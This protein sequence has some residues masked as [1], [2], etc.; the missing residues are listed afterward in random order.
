MYI[1][2]LLV[3]LNTFISVWFGLWVIPATFKVNNTGRISDVKWKLATAYFAILLVVN[4]GAVVAVYG[5]S[6]ASVVKSFVIS[7]LPFFAAYLMHRHYYS[8]IG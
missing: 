6:R 1:L 2:E 4:A 8:R 3:S 7:G 5:I